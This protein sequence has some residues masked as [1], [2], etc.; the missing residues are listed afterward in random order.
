MSTLKMRRTYIYA[1]ISIIVALVGFNFLSGLKKSPQ[2]DAGK[3][4]IIKVEVVNAVNE[5]VK[6]DIAVN[7][8]LNS[9]FKI[10]IFSEVTGR[11]LN[12]GKS[13]KEGVK[14]NAGETLLKLD[15]ENYRMN[16][17]AARSSFHSLLTQL[18]A[19]VKI[20]YPNH[21]KIWE[22][23]INHFNP[24]LSIQTLPVID[25]DQEKNYLVSKNVYTQY[26]NI[27][28]QEAQLAKYEIIAP[29]EGVIKNANINPNSIVRAGQKLAE[30]INP[31]VFELEVGVNLTQITKINIGDKVTLTSN[32]LAGEWQGVV[33]RIG[34][35]LDEKTMNFKVFIEVKSNTLYEGMYLKGLMNSFILDNVVKIPSNLIRNGGFVYTVQDSVLH[36]QKV[37]IVHEADN[38]TLVRGL[39]NDTKLISHNVSNAYE[40]MIVT[41]D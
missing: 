14:F 4:K 5:S 35:S 19:E 33:N 30:F 11:L 13:F 26:Y 2:K 16:L 38:F 39:N 3:A 12:S 34:E 21:F 17:N 32:D 1:V 15:D 22:N 8:R 6:A 23:Y 27:K 40:G 36:F 7:G 24:E 29:F 31:E 28:A 18:L 9:K 41:L 10:D 25:D 37:D 20:E